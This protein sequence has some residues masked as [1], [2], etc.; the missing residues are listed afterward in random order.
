MSR[1]NEL[2]FVTE[3]SDQTIRATMRQGSIQSN[4][5]MEIIRQLKCTADRLTICAIEIDPKR[6]KLVENSIRNVK[7]DSNFET[8]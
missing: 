8:R 6:C 1:V 5:E 7:A 2:N 3:A 4:I